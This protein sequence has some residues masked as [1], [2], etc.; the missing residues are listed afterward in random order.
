[1]KHVT[2][3]NELP[4]VPERGVGWTV[5]DA[6]L[7]LLGAQLLAVLWVGLF[8]A[9]AYG[10]DEPP[11]PLPITVGVA[12]NV[13]LWIGYLLGPIAVSR[14]RGNGIVAD[15]GA[16]LE[17]AD[18][19]IGLALGVF[20]QLVVLPV[21]YWPILRIVDGDP[22]GPAKELLA[23]VDS[24]SDW[25]VLTVSVVVVAPAVEELFYR[26]LFLRALQVRFGPIPAALISSAVFALV[27][28]QLLPLPGLFVFG[29]LAAALALYT[30]RLGPSWALHVGFNATTLVVLGLGS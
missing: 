21:L 1:M 14:W 28:R 29:L 26:G 30:G 5:S 23:T 2:G 8:F 18:L 13:G 7:V 27:H 12:A 11:D 16:R 10:G 20:T 15:L 6:V 9:A 24:A 3:L 25:L 17:A 22:S 4:A 19:P